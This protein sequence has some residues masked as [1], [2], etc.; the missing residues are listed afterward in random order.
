MHCSS[1][2]SYP[3]HEEHQKRVLRSGTLWWNEW[4]REREGEWKLQESSWRSFRGSDPRIL[5]LLMI[6]LLFTIRAIVMFKMRSA[7]GEGEMMMRVKERIEMM[8]GSFI[9]WKKKV[10]SVTIIMIRTMGEHELPKCCW[11]YCL[12]SLSSPSCC[13]T[14]SFGW[15]LIFMY[16]LWFTGDRVWDMIL[17]NVAGAKYIKKGSNDRSDISDKR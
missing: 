5:L 4:R 2:S 13:I 15:L 3:D 12:W 8:I 7:G 10:T 17:W 14:S 6:V 9:S 16:R 11:S 1:P